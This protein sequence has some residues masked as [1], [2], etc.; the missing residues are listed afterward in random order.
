MAN[1][2]LLLGLSGAVIWAL[3]NGSPSVVPREQ[4][5]ASQTVGAAPYV[6]PQVSA[7]R[8]SVLET[9]R[10]PV[11]LVRNVQH[12]FA[13]LALPSSDAAVVVTEQ[14]AQD[15]LE[16]KAA[17]EAIEMDGYK[18]VSIVGKASNGAWRAKGYRGVTEVLLTVDGTGRVSSD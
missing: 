4:Q 5:P 12:S 7:G 10:A 6:L 8:R 17:K 14:Q 3:I 11:P 16:R 1:N 15:D 2:F 9:R 13:P 18:R